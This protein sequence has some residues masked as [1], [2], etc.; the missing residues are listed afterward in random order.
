MFETKEQLAEE[1]RWEEAHRKWILRTLCPGTNREKINEE[2]WAEPNLHV[3][4]KYSLSDVGL[5]KVCQ[6]LKIPRPG[7]G[8]WAKKAA[9]KPLP[10]RP[11][12]PEL[13]YVRNQPCGLIEDVLRA[14]YS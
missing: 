2:L 11:P 12:L 8:Y 1:E 5:G 3:A 4:K 14:S 7:L 10:T 13:F 9:G 6:K